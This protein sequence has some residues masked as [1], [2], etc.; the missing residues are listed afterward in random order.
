MIEKLNEAGR[1]KNQNISRSPNYEDYELTTGEP[2]SGLYNYNR[3][4][5]ND[6]V[7]RI[8]DKSIESEKNLMI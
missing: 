8:L 4:Y 7:D 3:G 1:V 5:L 6:D 2:K